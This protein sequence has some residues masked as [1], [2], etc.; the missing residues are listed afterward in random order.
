LIRRN[1]VSRWYSD[2]IEPE[3]PVVQL[4]SVTEVVAF[5]EGVLFTVIVS[6]VIKIALGSAQEVYLVLIINCSEF[7]EG[8][9]FGKLKLTLPGIVNDVVAVATNEP[10]SVNIAN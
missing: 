5:K 3:E 10:L 6:S 1:S 9:I 4:R 7:P 2:G 8:Q